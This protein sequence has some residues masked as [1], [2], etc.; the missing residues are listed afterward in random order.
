MSQ[1]FKEENLACVNRTTVTHLR[2]VPV[3][4]GWLN[5]NNIDVTWETSWKS[6][7]YKTDV[8]IPEPVPVNLNQLVILASPYKKVHND[9]N[10]RHDYEMIEKSYGMF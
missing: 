2:G 1:Q 10:R 8:L 3:K 9:A 4:F 7:T 6:N 5:S